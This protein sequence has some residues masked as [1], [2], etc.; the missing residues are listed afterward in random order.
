MKH[1]L[2]KLAENYL[3][4]ENVWENSI[5]PKL[6]EYIKIPN[7]SPSYDPNWEEHG[8][9]NKAVDLI[10]EWCQQQPVK[11]IKVEKMQIP[12][13][14]PVLLI[15]IPGEQTENPILIYG[16][17]DKQ[18]EMQ[19]WLENLGPWLPVIAEGKLYGRGGADDGYSAFSAVTAVSYLQNLN[20]PHCR[21]CIL[22]EASEESGSIDLPF[23]LEK[24]YPRIGK[25]SL[26]IG[27]DSGCGNYDQLWGTTSL[28]GLIIG[29]L[30]IKVLTEGIHSGYGGGVVPSCF[31]ILR[32]LLDRIEDA[33]TGKIKIK[34]LNTPVPEQQIH[35]TK[36]LAATQKNKF[37][38]KF[39][40]AGHTEPLNQDDFELLLNQSWHPSLSIT[41]IKGM[42]NFSSSGNVI[43]PELTIKLSIRIPPDCDPTVAISALNSALKKDIPFN[44]E[45]EF[46]KLESA[47]GW[48]AKPL[49]PWL[50]EAC[51][52]ASQTFFQ[53]PAMFMGEGGSIPFMKILAKKFSEAEFFITGVLGPYSNAHGPNEFLHLEM[54]KKLTA[55]I[56][57]IIALH[58]ERFN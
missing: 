31:A 35:H 7:K 17:L 28:R 5:I 20:L 43:I 15:D 27:L 16:H 29:N 19:G 58:Y 12:G 25:P 41:G 57:S 45:V 53:K 6:M 9:M 2:K 23:Y 54:A 50:T 42:P 4:L 49:S 48:L 36:L 14:T 51:E 34:E 32:M 37:R 13:K 55:C 38:N 1:L 8:Y 21:V 40:F 18:P 39:P 52:N 24:L 46:I 26:I 47:E 3:F 44:A 22:I 56:A 11:G 33:S 10:Q 30:K